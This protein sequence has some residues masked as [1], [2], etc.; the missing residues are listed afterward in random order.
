MEHGYTTEHGITTP[1]GY[2]LDGLDANLI[3]LFHKFTQTLY[4]TG[5][6][7]NLPLN[8]TFD[9]LHK[10]INNSFVRLIHSSQSFINSQFPDNDKFD[11]KDCQLWEYRLGISASNLTP[12]EQRRQA[13]FR[14]LAYP[15]TAKARFSVPF[16]QKQITDAGFNVT[17]HENKFFQGGEWVYKSP[18]QVGSVTL[19]ATRHAN[20]T[21]HG[22]GTVHGSTGF[23]VIANEARNTPEKFVVGSGNLW[24]T[25][26]LGGTT[27]GTYATVPSYRQI[28]FKELIL[29]LKPA[30]L[31]A[32]TFIN[33]V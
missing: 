32:F 31:T 11:I 5:R 6:A 9:N 8:G 14:K 2:A 22:K 10:G 27:L 4:P 24:A 33:Y 30:H 17:I 25:F 19:E 23:E 1:H 12:I 16:L 28:E 20:S 26:F 21:L 3:D 15:G 7:F 18:S 29:K 13:V